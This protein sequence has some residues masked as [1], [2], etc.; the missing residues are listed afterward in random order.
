MADDLYTPQTWANGPGGGT[1]IS[2]PRLTHIESGIEVVDQAFQQLRDDVDAVQAGVGGQVRGQLELVDSTGRGTPTEGLLK[3]DTGLDL[4]IIGTGTVWR[5]IATAAISGGGAGGGGT[6][7]PTNFTA[8][9]NPD[10][11]IALAWTLP[12]PPGAETITGVTVREKFKSPT[13]VSGMPLAGSATSNTRTASTSTAVREYYVTCTF[14]S[15]GESAESNH[16][17]VYL[18][19]GTAPPDDSSTGGGGTVGGGSAGS[20]AEL[21]ALGALP[22]TGGRYNLG[23]GQSGSSHIDVGVSTVE[24][25]FVREGY[26]YL[27]TAGDGVIF[28]EYADGGR[29]SAN[30]K[31]P[32]TELREYNQDGTTKSAW[33]A[34]SGTHEFEY[35]IGVG[36]IWS[37]KPWMTIGQI[38]D[39]ASDAVAIKIKGTSRTSLDIIANFYDTDHPTKLVTGYNATQ[40]EAC[41]QVTIK[42][43]V[44]GGGTVRI[45]VNGVLKI[46]STAMVGKGSGHYWKLGAYGQSGTATGEAANATAYSIVYAN[47]I[48]H[49][50]AI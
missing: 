28:K 31:Y 13:G 19:Y 3:W 35:T 29:T 12:T 26:F 50:P 20:P 1:A 41:T 9:V 6:A 25:G 46:T 2:A 15:S 30:T 10:S 36:Q 11:S 49:T 23:I 16:V 48:T 45:Y 39:A 40:G 47:K 33:N 27:N 5:Q 34:S 22:K 43:Q 7:G 32:R 38:H 37:V 17:T 4:P 42:V 21:L 8:V 44:S 14:S 18:P 24:G